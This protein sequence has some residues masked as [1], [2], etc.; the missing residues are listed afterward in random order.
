MGIPDQ[1][2][3]IDNVRY[4]PLRVFASR[5]KTRRVQIL[6]ALLGHRSP[7]D[8][9]RHDH[10]ASLVPLVAKDREPANGRGTGAFQQRED[11]MIYNT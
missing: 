8:P 2:Q 3:R 11:A 9:S 10:L 6:L 4:E 1:R 5:E 7:P